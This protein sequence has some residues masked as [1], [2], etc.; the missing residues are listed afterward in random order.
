MDNANLYIS[1]FSSLLRKVLH[2]S[3]QPFVTLE[4]ELEQ[5]ELYLSIESLRLQHFSYHIKV[6][7]EIE[8]DA[9]KIPG[10]LIQPFVENAIKHGLSPKTGNKILSI[11]IRFCETAKL[12]IVVEDNGIGRF[13]AE[14]IR[15][16]NEKLL[17][18]QSRGMQLVEERLHLFNQYAEKEKLIHIADLADN[19]GNACG[20]RVVL[21]LPLTI[22]ET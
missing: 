11:E 5:L 6:D 17:P 22:N 2:T 21:N 20:T 1:K 15:M 18:H 12:Q 4:E 13:A 8:L 10:M 3:Q 7:E 19:R 9:V 14:T 16:Q